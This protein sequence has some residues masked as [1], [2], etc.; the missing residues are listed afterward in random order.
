MK[1]CTVYTYSIYIHRSTYIHIYICM[2]GYTVFTYI[3]TTVMFRGFLIIIL[4]ITN[5][6]AQ[7]NNNN[8]YSKL[9]II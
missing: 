5:T 9:E 4:I 6:L 2:F 1:V 7:K 8:V 3:P